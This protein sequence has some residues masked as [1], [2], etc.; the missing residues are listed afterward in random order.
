[1]NKADRFFTSEERKAI[2]DAV[3]RAELKTSGELV[4]MVVDRSSVYREAA[5]FG[6]FVLAG[7][8][9]M[10]VELAINGLLAA[11][12][13][14]E[15]AQGAATHWYAAAQGAELWTFLPLLLL[16][17]L[18]CRIVCSRFE[19]LRLLFVPPRR[20]EEAVVESSLR[21]FRERGLDRTRDA[22]GVLIYFSL[23]ERRVRVLGDRGI[24]AALT[25]DGWRRLA[26]RLSAAVRAG[27][28]AVE[29]AA[30]VDE[31]GD[32][33]GQRFPRRADDTNELPDD[34]VVAK[35]EE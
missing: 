1:M 12:R 24:D 28:A 5:V 2:S 13:D 6:G 25:A 14:W 19:G 22:T 29:V 21:L 4:V 15:A 32:L 8:L 17:Y 16:A 33:L 23:A 27:R 11:G 9:A 20:R 3:A 26:D 30:V 31:L 35:G 7:V 34:V 18:P 10:V